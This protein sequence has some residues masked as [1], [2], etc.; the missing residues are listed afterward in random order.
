MIYGSS[1]LLLWRNSPRLTAPFMA[2]TQLA[3]KLFLFNWKSVFFLA[4]K[5]FFFGNEINFVKNSVE[6]CMDFKLF[7]LKSEID[8]KS[9]NGN[10]HEEYF[11]YHL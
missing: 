1:L 11:E 4:L 7:E 10:G 2:K 8:E 3:C 6:K 5:K 9:S